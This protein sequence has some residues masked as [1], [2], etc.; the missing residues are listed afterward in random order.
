MLQVLTQ[1]QQLNVFFSCPVIIV[2][3]EIIATLKKNLFNIYKC[4]KCC[5]E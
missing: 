4:D 3:E 1:L 2:A 5:L